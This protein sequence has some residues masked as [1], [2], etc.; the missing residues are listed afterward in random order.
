MPEARRTATVDGTFRSQ[1]RI[2]QMRALP[3]RKPQSGPLANSRLQSS[4]GAFFIPANPGAPPAKERAI[5]MEI[6]TFK[7]MYLAELQE[8]VS[9]EEQLTEALLR[10]AQMASHPALKDIL[11]RH[12][13]E[14]QTQKMRLEAILRKHGADTRAHTDQA[15][16]ALVRETEKMLSILKGDDLRDAG[17]IASAQKL[18]HYEIAAYGTAAALAGQSGLRDEQQLLHESLEEEKRA[19]VLLTHIAKGEVNRDALAA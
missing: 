11:L 5:A 17:L 6:T 13:E 15:M 12:R 19:D 2:R 14:T 10:M 1:P 7:D 16:Q 8:L 4:I 9:V 18:E 3:D